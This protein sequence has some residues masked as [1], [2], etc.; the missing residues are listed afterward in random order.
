[1]KAS[2]VAALTAGLLAAACAGQ[3]VTTGSFRG[4]ANPMFTYAAAGR[5]LHTVV[6]G[7]PFPGA[8]AATQAAAIGA[9]QGRFRAQPTHLVAA[10][11]AETRT[12]SRLV[13]ALDP[14]PGVSAETLCAAP[15]HIAT[16]R[17]EH[18]LNALLAFC[19]HDIAYAETRGFVTRPGS[20]DDPAFT[21]LMVALAGNLLPGAD[22]TMHDFLDNVD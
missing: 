22:A 16:A 13:L 18:R 14:Q 20:P 8:E 4:G 1:M 7:D 5:D 2:V 17:A 19:Y 12:D 9:M 6:V 3:P 15:S 21:K 10:P 11:T